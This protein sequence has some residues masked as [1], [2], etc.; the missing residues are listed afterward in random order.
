MARELA[1][2]L[3]ELE[4]HARRIAA[5]ELEPAELRR[6]AEVIIEQARRMTR[7][8]RDVLALASPRVRA[9]NSAPTAT[10]TGAKSM[11]DRSH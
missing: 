2:P 5:G 10:A 6:E 7:I 9:L 1:A 11:R 4:A 8:V 3:A